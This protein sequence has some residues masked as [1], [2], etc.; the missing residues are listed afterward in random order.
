ML[1]MDVSGSM[2]NGGKLE[3]AKAAAKAYVAQMRPGDRAGLITFNTQVTYVQPITSDP[4]A[5]DSAIGSLR[6]RDDT[7]MY[8]ALLKAVEVLQVEGGRKAIIVL[9]DGLDN[10]S[11]V[12]TGDVISAVGPGGLSISTIGLGDPASLRTNFGLD[13]E[14]LK[15]LAEQAG[16]VYGY[17]QDAESLQAL[18][19]TYGRA[20]QSEYTI[21]YTSP[22]ML[23]DGINRALTV[24]LGEGSGISAGAQYNPGG[25]LP[26]VAEKSWVL[27]LGV[28]A[29]LVVLAFLPG[30]IGL[31][32]RTGRKKSHKTGKKKSRIKLK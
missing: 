20:L 15:S 13:E 28:L 24:S 27:F 26:E 29:G 19:E 1:V 10:R 31:F 9:T 25:V 6:A 11:K 17:A 14:G 2:Y 23:R 3:A 18:Y 32:A 4:A 16:G 5:L 12:T 21:I 30:I 7:A 8:D 22:S